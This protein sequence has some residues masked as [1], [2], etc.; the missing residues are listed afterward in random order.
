MK[1]IFGIIIFL[2]TMC[3]ISYGFDTDFVALEDTNFSK[4]TLNLSKYED[5]IAIN[6]NTET[7]IPELEDFTEEDIMPQASDPLTIQGHINKSIQAIQDFWA[8]QPE[9]I[10]TVTPLFRE[11]LTINPDKGPFDSVYGRLVLQSNV[12]MNFPEEGDSTYKYNLN[13]INVLIDAKSRDGKDTYRFMFDLSH[14]HGRSFMQ[15]LMKDLFYE[16]TRVP[17]HSILF[18]N[19]RVGVGLEGTQSPYTLPFLSRAQISRNFSNIRK[20]GLRVRGDYKYVDYDFGGYSSDTYFTKFMPGAEFNGWFNIKP[21]ANMDE[22]KYGKIITGTGISAGKH[23][24]TGYFVYG[25]GMQYNYKKFWTRLEYAI[26]DGSNGNTGLSA[27]RRHGWYFLLGYRLTKK[28]ELLAR[29]DEFNPDSSAGNKK[30]REYTT[31][32]NY[33]IKG[34]AL[35]LVLNYIFCENEADIYSHRFLIGAQLAL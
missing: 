24:S 13:L 8:L 23:D 27:K 7:Y 26:A 9:N 28:M 2:L 32:I 16:T 6:E 21:L 15:N 11:Q 12:D 19:S 35:K 14:Q 5:K 18:G 10:D 33:Y 17:H 3:P 1:K 29:Y 34:Q 20:I 25:S 31:G 30:R 4:L 22:K